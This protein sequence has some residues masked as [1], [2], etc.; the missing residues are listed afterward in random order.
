M[1]LRE[2]I[3][4]RKSIRGYMNR[5][6]S[7][8]DIQGV[9]KLASRAISSVN[10]QPWE[11]VV[12][13]GD[14]LK[15][16]CE[17]NIACFREKLPTDIPD[18]YGLDG[19]YRKRQVEI[20]KA[21][22][23]SM[24]INKDDKERR[25]WWT[26]RGYRFFDAPVGI[27]ICIDV[28]LNENLLRTEIGCIAQNIALAAMEYGLSTCVANQPAMYQRGMRRYAF[29][30]ENKKAIL[31]VAIGYAD[32]SFAANHIVST[33]EDIDNLTTWCGFQ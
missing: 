31:G 2:A 25:I 19:I 26:E 15:K 27:L 29:V 6:V 10:C 12:L 30:P 11:F 1:D 17:D 33:R 16:V 4:T 20:G 9:L 28:S 21:L 3:E 18:I 13:T 23:Q 7:R 22:L 24:G 32:E 5:P 8:E 14:V